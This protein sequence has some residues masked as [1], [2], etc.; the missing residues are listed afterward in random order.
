MS[1][2]LLL[3]VPHPAPDVDHDP[4]AGTE[5]AERSLV[6]GSFPENR[7]VCK[8][9]KDTWGQGG[10]SLPTVLSRRREGLRGRIMRALL[11]TRIKSQ[12]SSKQRMK[13][14]DGKS[15]S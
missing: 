13:A 3:F 9:V 15:F 14:G 11:N 1:A 8:G 4:V 10:F 5:E 12:Y 2:S 6:I 7:A